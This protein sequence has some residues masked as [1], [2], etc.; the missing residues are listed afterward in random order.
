[1]ERIRVGVVVYPDADVDDICGTRD[2]LSSVRLPERRKE[3]DESPFRVMPIAEYSSDLVVGGGSTCSPHFTFLDCPKLD[4]LIV[5]GGVGARIQ[6][7]NRAVLDWL[8][9]KAAQTKTVAS[10]CSGSMLLGFAN[11]PP[12][13]RDTTHWQ[14]I[15]RM[16]RSIAKNSAEEDRHFV[17]DGNIYRS[18]GASP[19]VDLA[20]NI[21]DKYFGMAT[22]RRTAEQIGYDFPEANTKRR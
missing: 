3:E 16:R 4:V 11:L 22:A 21:I 9:L 15:E 12:G 17:V 10:V 7:T 13:L 14:S 6:A 19:G 18:S 8:K 20:L 2:V 5:P 1:M